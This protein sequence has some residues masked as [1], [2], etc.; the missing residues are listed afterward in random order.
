MYRDGFA[1]QGS[2][3]AKVKGSTDQVRQQWSDLLV[4]L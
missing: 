4:E 1:P 3:G 2:L